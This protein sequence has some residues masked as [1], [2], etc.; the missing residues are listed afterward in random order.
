MSKQVVAG[1]ARFRLMED[2]SLRIGDDTNYITIDANGEVLQVGAATVYEDVQFPV[3]VGKIPGANAPTWEQMGTLTNHAEYAFSVDDYID[4]Q[5]GE[6]SHGWY[7]G[8]AS[9]VHAHITLKTA[10]ST[11]GNRYVKITVYLAIADVNGVWSE[12]G[13]YTAEQTIP[14]G[15]A[16]L[17]HYLLDLGDATLTGYHIGSQIKARVRRIAATGGTEYADDVYITQ[18]GM[19]MQKNRLGSRTEYAA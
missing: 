11:G 1:H 6:P 15:T 17:T 12:L 3:A 13:P 19:H 9:D 4:C 7:E 2:G 5:A 14:T 8:S 10:Q 18:V 16:A